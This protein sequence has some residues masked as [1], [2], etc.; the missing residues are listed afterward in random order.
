MANHSIGDRITEL[1]SA[2]QRLVFFSFHYD[3]DMRRANVVFDTLRTT[4]SS[5]VGSNI[6]QTARELDDESVKRLI[7]EGVDQA[8]VTCV[9][10]GAHTWA[11]RW[12]RYEIA[13]SVEHG[14]GLLAVRIDSIADTNT[15]LTSIAGWNPMAY[16]GIGKVEGNEYFFFENVGGQW[17]RYP[18]HALPVA[19]PIYL[20]DMTTGYV[21]PLSVGLPE[22]DYVRQNGPQ[23][24]TNWIDT[25]AKQAGK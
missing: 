21:Q 13:R 25:A 14:N 11:E 6:W 19:K 1:S 22:Y 10:V 16:V 12:V 3:E 7:C 5:F 24:L 20:P 18:D 8:S 17:V 2:K 9:L 4:D 15:L 23:N